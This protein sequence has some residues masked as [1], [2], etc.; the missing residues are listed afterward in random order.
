[1]DKERII[2]FLASQSWS[3]D[4]Y[5]NFNQANP[6]LTVEEMLDRVNKAEELIRASFKWSSTSQ[7]FNYWD[8]AE[9]EYISFLHSNKP[10]RKFDAVAAVFAALLMACLVGGIW[11]L[12]FCATSFPICTSVAAVAIGFFALYGMLTEKNLEHE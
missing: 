6:T 5:L 8:D 9:G 11:L 12:T 2:D 10:K 4:F 3:K 7:G 1:M